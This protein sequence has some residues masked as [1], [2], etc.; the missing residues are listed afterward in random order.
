M[1]L[2]Q[3]GRA[4]AI[5]SLHVA[6]HAIGVASSLGNEAPCAKGGFHSFPPPGEDSDLG[7]IWIVR[8]SHDGVDNSEHT[9]VRYHRMP[10]SLVDRLMCI[11]WRLLHDGYRGDW[12]AVLPA[13]I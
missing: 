11:I 7:E 9:T 2:L 12:V 13:A 6:N 4:G 3:D 5:S 10:Y 1:G 8:Q